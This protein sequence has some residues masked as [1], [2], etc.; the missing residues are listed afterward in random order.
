MMK[1]SEVSIVINMSFLVQLIR[2]TMGIP[3]GS[4]R[5]NTNHL[6]SRVKDLIRGWHLS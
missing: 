6:G 1:L 5:Y 4:F 3:G 2:V